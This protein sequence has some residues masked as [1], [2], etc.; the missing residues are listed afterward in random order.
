MPTP[1]P[2]APTA[3]KWLIAIFL[4]LTLT[5]AISGYIHFKHQQESIK[6]TAGAELMA[7]AHLKV[8]QIVNWRNE[9]L[10]D[11]NFTA[12]NQELAW[13]IKN[14]LKEPSSVVLKNQIIHWI[15]ELKNAYDYYQ[16]LLLDPSGNVRLSVPEGIA[17]VDQPTRQLAVEA[18]NSQKS[19]IWGLY[20]KRTKNVELTSR[21]QITLVM[22]A[23]LPTVLTVIPSWT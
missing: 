23:F 17:T 21:Y 10:A 11:G 8:D 16:V 4:L 18:L 5:I 13:L 22:Y 20:S 1:Q 14:Y 9:R 6:K 2:Q 19:L 15:A 7:I 12:K 3:P